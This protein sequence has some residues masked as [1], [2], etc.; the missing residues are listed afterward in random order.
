MTATPPGWEGGGA[1]VWN[2]PGQGSSLP[3]VLSSPD[4]DP[5][6]QVT[7]GRHSSLP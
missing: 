2:E 3:W 1:G 7:L 5:P 4:N 6:G